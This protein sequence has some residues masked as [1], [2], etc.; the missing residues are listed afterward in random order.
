MR[1][2]SVSSTRMYCAR[3]GNFHAQHFFHRQAIA[4][5]IRK[6]RQIIHAVGERDPLRI[7]LRFAGFLDSGVQVTD[8]RLG[9]NTISP[10]SSSTTRS[11]PCVEGCCGPM[12]RTIVCV[13]AGRRFDASR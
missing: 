4:Q 3:F 1:V 10:S 2:N 13:C 7:S 5:I 12:L 6:R 11:T 8:Y 9:L